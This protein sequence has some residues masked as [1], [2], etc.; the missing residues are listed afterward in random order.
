MRRLLGD[1]RKRFFVGRWRKPVS[2]RIERPVTLTVVSMLHKE[3]R[4]G[5]PETIRLAHDHPTSS[6]TTSGYCFL[7]P[8]F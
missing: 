6:Y 5:W 3:H 2:S 8:D 7:N 4:I 1:G